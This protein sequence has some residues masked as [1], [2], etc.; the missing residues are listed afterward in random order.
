MQPSASRSAASAGVLRL[1]VQSKTFLTIPFL[2]PRLRFRMHRFVGLEMPRSI[3]PDQFPF[4]LQPI[5]E[6]ITKKSAVGAV[7]LVRAIQNLFDLQRPAD[8][9]SVKDY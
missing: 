7:D 6:V 1:V 2:I 3:S 4:R 5:F 8:C 9:I